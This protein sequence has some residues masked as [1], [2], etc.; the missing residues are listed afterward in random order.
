MPAV[1]S[2]THNRLTT[3]LQARKNYNAFPTMRHFYG[4]HLGCFSATLTD[5][6]L[7]MKTISCQDKASPNELNSSITI[8][9]SSVDHVQ[10]TAHGEF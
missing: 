6:L 10:S 1:T 2:H 3:E 5:V 4:G 7:Y 9:K 8:I